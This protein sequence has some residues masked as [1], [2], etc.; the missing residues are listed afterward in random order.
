MLGLLSAGQDE[1]HQQRRPEHIAQ[2]EKPGI[3]LTD[4]LV[5]TYKGG[6]VG[7]QVI[8][9]GRQQPGGAKQNEEELPGDYTAPGFQLKIHAFIVASGRPKL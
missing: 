8:E 4:R 6:A 2:P 1:Q 7:Y 5:L 9:V 3:G